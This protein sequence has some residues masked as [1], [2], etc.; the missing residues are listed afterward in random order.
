MASSFHTLSLS[1]HYPLFQLPHGSS[2]LHHAAVDR[3]SQSPLSAPSS[4]AAAHLAQW[5]VRRTV[6][7]SFR[8]ELRHSRLVGHF[9]QNSSA[10][11]ARI[12]GRIH[13]LNNWI[14]SVVFEIPAKNRTILTLD[15]GIRPENGV[16]CESISTALRPCYFSYYQSLY[17]RD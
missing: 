8:H 3:C 13:A 16:K 15:Y 9:C 2:Q 1:L 17:L 7:S 10:T 5:I 12:S 4:K 14:T 6:R 11:L